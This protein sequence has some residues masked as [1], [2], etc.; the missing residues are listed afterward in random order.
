MALAKQAEE[1]YRDVECSFGTLR[2]YHVPDAVLLSGSSFFSEPEMPMVSMRTATGIQDRPA[3]KGDAAFDEWQK[4]VAEI[5]ERQFTIRQ[6]RGFVLALRDIE[7]DDIDISQPPPVKLAQEIYNG[8]WPQDEILRK[9][10]W[11]D[12]TVFTMREDKTKVLDALNIM[13]QVYEPT[14]EMVEDVKKNL[15]SSS[16]QK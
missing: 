1:N 7:W 5:R 2:V 4:E 12:F 3:K 16:K 6:S 8:N 15:V 9:M 13:N 10:A 14:E 11:L